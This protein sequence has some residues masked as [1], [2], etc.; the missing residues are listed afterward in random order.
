[1]DFGFSDEQETLRTDVREFFLNE[2]PED[3]EPDV[4]TMF[5]L[6][7]AVCFA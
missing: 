4:D 2:M 3:F 6:T 5:S 1:M 7:K